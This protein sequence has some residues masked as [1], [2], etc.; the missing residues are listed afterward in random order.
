MH[1]MKHMVGCLLMIGA[2]VAIRF[3]GD[4]VPGW[5]AGLVVLACPIMM[6]WMVVMMSRDRRA[7]ARGEAPRVDG[8]TD[9]HAHR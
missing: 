1:H 8:A 6:I 3:A 4:G 7:D 5:A 2:I 9:E